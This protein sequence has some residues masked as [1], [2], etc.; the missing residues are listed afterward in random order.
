MILVIEC[1]IAVFALVA[2][3]GLLLIGR[4]APQQ[5]TTSIADPALAREVRLLSTIQQAGASF[6]G[7]VGHL[8]GVIPK[9]Q[10]EVSVLRQRLIRA[11]YRGDAAVSIV[12]G[13]K[14]LLMA[15]AVVLIYVTPIAR[16]NYV[17]VTIGALAFGFLAPDF[18]LGRHI[19]ARQR[20]IRAGLPDVLDLLV[21]CVEAG[22]SLDQ[23][24]AR[25]AEELEM[26]CPVLSDEL[27]I[28]VLE[29]RAGCPR[30][31]AWKHMAER[32]D[33]DTVR[34]LV[35]MLVQ[36]EQFGTSIAKTLR[37]HSDTYRVKRVQQIEER[38]AKTTVKILFPLVIFIFPS[39][40]LVTLGPA[41]IQM[42]ESFQ[43]GFAH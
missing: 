43:N 18:W 16:L 26:A 17:F 36:S 10:A 34:N 27:K 15:L 4:E 12:Y 9:S 19:A 30:G 6:G 3:A 38:A 40:F 33:V 41:L 5:V 39:L 1:F 35:S 13:A 21:V 31:D 14:V 29:Q 11:G 22:L 37:V 42:F 32:T 8:E 25:T 28:V 20:K 24:V 2:S 7:M 23:A